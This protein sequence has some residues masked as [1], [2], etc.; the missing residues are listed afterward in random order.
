LLIYT[1][2]AL[3]AIPFNIWIENMA[4]LSGICSNKFEFYVVNK[5]TRLINSQIV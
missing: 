2:A 5:D 4:V 1:L 3:V